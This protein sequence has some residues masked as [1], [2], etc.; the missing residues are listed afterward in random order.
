MLQDTDTMTQAVLLWIFL[1]IIT[2]ISSGELRE[3][4]TKPYHNPVFDFTAK[5]M[6]GSLY[7]DASY[8]RGDF[9]R[10]KIPG[11]RMASWR[12]R[13][14]VRYDIFVIENQNTTNLNGLNITS[15][16]QDIWQIQYTNPATNNLTN[17][18]CDHRG[19]IFYPYSEISVTVNSWE[20]CAA[21]C[22]ESNLYGNKCAAFN[23]EGGLKIDDIKCVYM[24]PPCQRITNP[25][26][27]DDPM[28]FVG[29]PIGNPPKYEHLNQ[30][31]FHF[32]R[33]DF[34]TDLKKQLD[35][36]IL[37]KG[38]LLNSLFEEKELNPGLK[39]Q[40]PRIV[41]ANS[42]RA[43]EHGTALSIFYVK[44]DHVYSL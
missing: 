43:I 12:G 20:E 32:V 8:I 7:H 11:F 40:S 5:M 17:V 16:R 18:T 28:C 9:R 3:V 37:K 26:K 36:L 4:E 6:P 33:Y 22:V 25:P 44:S 29:Y 42:I 10:A 2:C 13:N 27:I 38:S 24:I 34:E 14:R 30:N 39:H 35:E 19:C 23:V 1:G 31:W 15:V 21:K 41:V